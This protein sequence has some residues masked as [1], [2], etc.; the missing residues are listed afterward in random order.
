M[1]IVPRTEKIAVG[2]D[3]TGHVRTIQVVF[4]EERLWPCEQN[5]G[6]HLGK[7]G[8]PRLG[9]SKHFLQQKGRA[10]D[11]IKEWGEQKTD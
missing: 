8:G 1:S 4:K 2:A 5:R 6:E 11:H 9:T 10:S 3:L 7:H